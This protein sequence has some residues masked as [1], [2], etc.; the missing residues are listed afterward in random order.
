MN[1][2]RDEH[3]HH[4]QSQNTKALVH[5]DMLQKKQKLLVKI[6]IWR[7]VEHMQS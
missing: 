1:E 6:T 5:W 3:M 4:K 2:D 7:R